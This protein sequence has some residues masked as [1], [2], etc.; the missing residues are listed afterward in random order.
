MQG[1]G[2]FF[3]KGVKLGGALVMLSI[4]GCTL[5][6]MN[7]VSHSTLSPSSQPLTVDALGQG[8]RIAQLG[9]EQHPRILSLYGGEYSDPKL[10]RMVAKIVG[11]LAVSVGGQ[12]EAYRITIL[13]M[14]MSRAVSWL[15]PMI[16][17]KLRPLSPMKWRILL[18]I[19][20]CCA[21]KSKRRWK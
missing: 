19:T 10:E 15:W 18:L 14:F 1:R 17:L 11:K 12:D 21:R 13:V 2:Y 7:K 5:A 3:N 4:A 6:D 20:A 9:A 16:R 8:S